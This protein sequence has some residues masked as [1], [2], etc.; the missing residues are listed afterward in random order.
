MSQQGERIVLTRRGV[1]TLR[2]A[3]KIFIESA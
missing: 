3:R 1:L 2:L